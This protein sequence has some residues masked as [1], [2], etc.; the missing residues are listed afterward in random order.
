MFK[1]IL[2]LVTAVS[3]LEIQREQDLIRIYKS[4]GIEIN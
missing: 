3:D 2:Y 4:D 1:Q